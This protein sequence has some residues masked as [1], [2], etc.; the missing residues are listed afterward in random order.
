MPNP[1]ASPRGWSSRANVAGF[2]SACAPAQLVEKGDLSIDVGHTD[3]DTNS[4]GSLLN[5]LFEWLEK[6]V[7]REDGSALLHRWTGGCTEDRIGHISRKGN[8]NEDHCPRNRFRVG[9]IQRNVVFRDNA[10]CLALVP[11]R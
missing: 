3:R 1:V 4:Q 6:Q 11:S 5:H 10:G 7:I 8:R 2:D 9:T